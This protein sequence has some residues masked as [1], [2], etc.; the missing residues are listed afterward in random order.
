[1]TAG[2]SL[3]PTTKN[4]SCGLE[5]RM[6]SLSALRARGNFEVMLP[7]RSKT[8]PMV[9]GASSVEKVLMV[10]P[11]LLSKM[12][13]FSFSRPVTRRFMGSVTVIGTRTRLTSMWMAEGRWPALAG[14]ASPGTGGGRGG[15]A[16]VPMGVLGSLSG[17]SWARQRCAGAARR[18]RRIHRNR[19]GR[20][21]RKP[22][23]DDCGRR[24][25]SFVPN[26]SCASR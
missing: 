11:M 20:V 19:T 3:K 5:V 24:P 13:K 7:L 14:F 17:F 2:R 10:C 6:N 9:T 21:R 22:T 8:M 4:S 25:T 1:M 12:A 16:G 18:T 26:L 15:F 23:G